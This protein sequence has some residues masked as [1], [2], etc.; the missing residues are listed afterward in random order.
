MIMNRREN[1]GIFMGLMTNLGIV[2]SGHSAETAEMNENSFLK[3]IQTYFDFGNK[4]TGRPGDINAA[5]W[6]ESELAKLGFKTTRQKLSVMGGKD[7]IS[8]IEYGGNKIQLLPQYPLNLTPESGINAEFA[9]FLPEQKI[10]NVTGKIILLIL[11]YSRWSS[12]L[13]PYIL[14]PL[15][16]AANG[17]ASAVIIA[18]TGPSGDALALNTPIKLDGINIPIAI[19]EQSGRSKLISY[20]P[21]TIKFTQSGSLV[22]FDSYNLIGKLD[23]GFDKWLV[24]SSPRS[25]WFSCAGERGPGVAVWLALARH[26]AKSKAKYNLAFISTSGHEFENFGTEILAQADLPKSDKTQLWLHLGAGFAANDWFELGV[27]LSKLNNVDAQR[28]L[29][30]SPNFKD[31]CTKNF[32]NQAGLE[33]V[34]EAS[35]KAAGEAGKIVE[36]GYGNIIAFAGAHRFH[37]SPHDNMDCVNLHATQA[38]YD[39]LLQTL[40]QL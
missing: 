17:G 11:P 8:F 34:R 33:I 15:S 21:Q 19:I 2:T 22:N 32:K 18:T 10:T 14:N 31:I 20:A 27:K 23:K 16:A 39:S 5:I 4:Q 36:N 38:V 3:D 28:I 35:A 25:G 40:K 1:I 26:L 6:Q 29:Y 12:I 9:Y 24:V 7:L 30:S 37:H 13:H